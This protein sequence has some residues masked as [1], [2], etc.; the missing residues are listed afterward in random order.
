[1]ASIL[2]KSYKKEML[3]HLGLYN[4][5]VTNNVRNNITEPVFYS[6]GS[7]GV[8]HGPLGS[9]RPSRAYAKIYIYIFVI[10]KLGGERAVL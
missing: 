7:Q 3:R 6:S 9:P 1:M 5:P 10:I 2:F 4:I 8:V